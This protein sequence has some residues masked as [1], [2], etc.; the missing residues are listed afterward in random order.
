MKD[1]LKR[2]ISVLVFVL[3]VFGMTPAAFPLENTTQTAAS[4]TSPAVKGTPKTKSRD[5]P[6]QNIFDSSSAKVE[7]VADS[8]EYSKDSQ[9]MIARGNAVISYQGTR[10]LA[11]Y[12]EVET[13]AKKAY[14][15][16]HVMIFRG[17][18]PRLQGEEI[19]YDFDKHT[20]SFPNARAIDEPWYARG[21]E[22]Q[23]VREG[24]QK[25]KNGHVTSCSLEKPHYEIRAKRA[26]LYNDV[27][28]VMYNATIYVLGKPVFWLPYVNIPLNWPDIPF[29]V[30]Y[31]YNTKDGASFGIIKEVTFNQHLWGKATVDWRQKRGVG[32]GW[33]QY[34]DYGKWAKGNIKLYWTGDRK[35]PS[36]LG[37]DPNS[38]AA[39]YTFDVL[40]K[41]KHGRG[42]ISWRHRTDLDDKTHVLLRYHR[43]A[44][45]YFVQEFS[46][47]E[48]WNNNQPHSFVTTTR[49]SERYG[50]MVHLEKRMNNFE[51]LVE[52]MPEVRLDWKNQPFFT[53]KIFNESRVQFDNLK[54]MSQAYAKPTR[55]AIRTD[56]YSRW[57]APL[58][59]KDINF[60]PYAGYRGTEY[61]HQLNSNDSQYR[62][63]IDYG[64]DLR[65]HFY[66][67]YD[68]SFEKAGIEVNQLR[69]I[70]E[71]SVAFLG[72]TSTVDHEKLIHFDT[73]DKVDDA[74]KVILGLENRLQTK[75]VVSGKTERVD[76]VSLNTFLFFDMMP[77]HEDPSMKGAR[78]SIFENKLVLRPYEWL[79]YQARVQFDFANHYL[80]RADQDIILRKGKWRFLF[81][82]SQVHD[83]FDFTTD[84]SV[85]KSQQFIV[86]ARYKMNPL[87]MF[88]GYVRWDTSNR[89]RLNEVNAID[90][91]NTP[92][93]YGIQEWEVS[94]V[95]DLH[96]FLLEFGV[97]ARHS[98][99]NS[100][101]S[102]KNKMNNTVFAKF[103]M[104]AVP[105]AA[106]GTAGKAP[107]SAP[108]I[109][110]TVAGANESGGFF[111]SPMLPGDSQ[112]LPSY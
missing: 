12:A 91:A 21:E 105:L 106:F 98:L 93:G 100:A 20:G 95:R 2:K 28:L 14:A 57:Y 63:V 84:Q 80:K 94:A 31:G 110:E 90:A 17:D 69:H 9:K 36:S 107:F 82:Y 22:V 48:Y 67:F 24:V 59:W 55:T 33:K 29:Q 97:N 10:I 49:N 74:A 35:A 81:G 78:F 53:D 92:Q 26:V 52:R 11:D 16:G 44:D 45:P 46:E 38:G 103:T 23:Q 27:K 61:S 96:D 54:L 43:V 41:R 32:G 30:T 83:F 56:A 64:A 89:N 86:D 109:G 68:V 39:A 70:F 19:Y 112:P 7:A 60:T 50:A 40:E 1:L 104:K 101:N 79:Q 85:Q 18:E 77:S 102:N 87:W 99:V 42:Q 34:Y 5:L 62:S 71:P 75:R 66:R 73:V 37:V 8:L 76:I 51:T 108:R 6:V 88:G 15:K 13:D 111:D 3:V 65:T 58:K 25:V 47:E 72:A 4:K